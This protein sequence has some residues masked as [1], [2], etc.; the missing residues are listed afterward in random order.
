MNDDLQ[1]ALNAMYKNLLFRRKHQEHTPDE[2]IKRVV[3]CCHNFFL[4]MRTAYLKYDQT[5]DLCLPN[6]AI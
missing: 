3:N 6:D 4:N 5:D 2:N 1:A